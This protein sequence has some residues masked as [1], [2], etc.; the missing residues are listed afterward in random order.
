MVSAG[1]PHWSSELGQVDA[2]REL[3]ASRSGRTP[4]AQLCWLAGEL[5]RGSASTPVPSAPGVLGGSPP[6]PPLSSRRRSSP[7]V[8]V[9]CSGLAFPGR[10]PGPY[11]SAACCRPVRRWWSAQSAWYAIRRGRMSLSRRS[12]CARSWPANT[13]SSSGPSP[14]SQKSSMRWML[15]TGS[16]GRPSLSGMHSMVPPRVHVSSPEPYPP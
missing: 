2:R 5:G 16:D 11:R 14:L 15:T 4:L 9:C 7:V 12:A 8:L 6:G 1:A 3:G 13:E 10:S